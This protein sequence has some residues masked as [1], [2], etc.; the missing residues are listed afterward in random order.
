MTQPINMALY[1]YLVTHGATEQDAEQAARLVEGLDASGIVT[2]AFLRAELAELKADL[3]RHTT[4][5]LVWTTAIYAGIVT[6]VIAIV[7][8]LP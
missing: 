2:K 5:T 8:W 1:R 4:Q 7:R 3:F 6:V